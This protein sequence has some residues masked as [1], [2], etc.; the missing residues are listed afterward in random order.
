MDSGVASD[1]DPLSFV[2]MHGDR[3][4]CTGEARLLRQVTAFLDSSN[5]ESDL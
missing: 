3:F 4:G 5:P 2:V 1:R